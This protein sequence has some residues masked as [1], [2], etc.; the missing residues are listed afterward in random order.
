[1][2][3]P[4]L[5]PQRRVPFFSPERA[6]TTEIKSFTLMISATFHAPHC[7]SP[8]TYS[9]MTLNSN[10]VSLNIQLRAV[11]GGRDALSDADKAKYA[12]RC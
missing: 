4:K 6:Y 10:D 3:L 8:R 2:D 12:P 11:L 9:R 1:M 7:A 5:F